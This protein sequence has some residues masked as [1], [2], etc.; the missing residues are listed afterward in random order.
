MPIVQLSRK[1]LALSRNKT[2][3]SLKS[4]NLSVPCVDVMGKSRRILP[5]G[6]PVFRLAPG[7]KSRARVDSCLTYDG[8][9]TELKG[10]PFVE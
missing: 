9:Y 6:N 10:L 1:V 7:N 4:F 8:V 5:Q 3:I 2:A